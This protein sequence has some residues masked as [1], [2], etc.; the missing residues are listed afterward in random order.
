MK[1]LR[2]YIDS[3]G[4]VHAGVEPVLLCAI[5][6]LCFELMR[7]KY[8]NAVT[9]L[10]FGRRILESIGIMN[11]SPDDCQSGEKLSRWGLV[12]FS[13]ELVG[14]FA[15]AFRILG[16]S[17][18]FSNQAG[19]LDQDIRLPIERLPH[20]IP[21]A[22]TSA[23]QAQECLELLSHARDELRKKLVQKAET[24]ISG[25][26]RNSLHPGIL[27]CITHCLSR[28]VAR[29][30]PSNIQMRISKL[31]S[32]HNAWLA[33]LQPLVRDA[34]TYS[35]PQHTMLLTVLRAKHLLAIHSLRTC[36]AIHETV[37]DAS[38]QDFTSMVDLLER[39]FVLLAANN[40]IPGVTSPALPLHPEAERQLSFSIE[41]GVLPTMALIGFKCRDPHLRRKI[42]AML[43]TVQRR[44]GGLYSAGMGSFI[45]QIIGV[46]ELEAQK[47]LINDF[48]WDADRPLL[49]ARDVPEMARFLDISMWSQ[50]DGIT[51]VVAARFR[52]EDGED[53]KLEIRE[54]DWEVGRWSNSNS[55]PVVFEEVGVTRLPYSC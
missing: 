48:G 41:P 10:Q 42:I 9:H 20:S 49:S 19:G 40:T 32:A 35:S 24:T 27:L 7:G 3:A 46:E 47:L 18:I 4:K 12:T 53:G 45:G 44:E 38:F 37:H 22:F 23:E 54:W 30:S 6:F 16:N 15:D 28:S 50:G 31:I 39:F 29:R 17:I 5:L 55:R 33:A 26:D 34:L 36:T 1:S 51:R 13:K 14:A 11:A 43:R 52:H 8:R 2:S 25:S 21:T